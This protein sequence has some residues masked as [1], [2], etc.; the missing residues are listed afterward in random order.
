MLPNRRFA[1]IARTSPCI[2]DRAVQKTIKGT[3]LEYDRKPHDIY[4]EAVNLVLA[5][6]GRPPI[7]NITSPRDLVKRPNA[8]VVTGHC[9]QPANS[10]LNDLD[11]SSAGKLLAHFGLEERGELFEIDFL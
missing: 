3:A 1:R 11:L 6:Y 4:L 7:E 9:G 8:N 2:S 5:R 10:S